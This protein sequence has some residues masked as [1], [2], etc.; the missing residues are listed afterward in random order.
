MG[1]PNIKDQLS[2]LN[3]IEVKRQG[4]ELKEI[5]EYVAAYK[6][7]LYKRSDVFQNDLAMIN[8]SLLLKFDDILTVDEVNKHGIN[9]FSVLWV[10]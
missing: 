5:S 8:E 1:H 4:L 3:A 9:F 6:A 10:L 2:E 7:C